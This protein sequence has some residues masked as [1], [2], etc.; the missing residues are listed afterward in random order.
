MFLLT[1]VFVV[2][3]AASL[4][5]GLAMRR[6]ATRL[7]VVVPPRP[8]RWHSASTPTMGGVGIAAATL[9]GFGG[10]ALVPGVLGPVEEWVPVL[11][12]AVAMFL[13]G[14]LDDRLQLSPVAKL[15]ASL[16]IGAFL[17]SALAASVPGPA[18]PTVYTLL[19]TIGFAGLCH[20]INLLDNMDGL[21]AGVVLI[22]AAFLAGLFGGDLGLPL[23]ALLV[24]VAGALLGFLCW[25]RPK[26]R[27]F[28][29]DSGSL[30]IGAVVGGASLVPLFGAAGPVALESTVLVVLV[31]V[32]PLFD[33]GFVLILRRLAGRSATRGGTDHVSHR[34]VSLGFSERRAV[35]ALY[36]LGAVGGVV[37]VAARAGGAGLMLAVA[38]L[39]LVVVMLLGIYLARVP[40]YYAEDFQALQ[41]SSFAPFLKDLAF[42][43]HAGEV[44]PDLVLIP[45][46]YYFAYRLRFEGAAFDENLQYFTASLPIVLGLK[47][48]SLYGSG[49]YQRSWSTFELRDVAVVLRGVWMGSLLAVLAVAFLYRFQG[50]SR[51]VFLIDGILLTVAVVA[52]RASFQAMS[53]V[54]SIRSKRSRRVVVYGAG[55]FGQLLVREMRAN[56]KWR[57]NPVAFI[58][59]D[60]LKRHRWIVGVPVRG[61]IDDLEDTVRKHGADE[62]IL[63]SPSVNG[64]MEQRIREICA[65]LDRP[66]R[67]FR[68]EIR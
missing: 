18:V 17:V 23:I 30:F 59:D 19:A 11:A 45:A 22:A 40:A 4:A 46:C 51:V 32:V 61:A 43:W 56:A 29:G 2:A 20:A 10:A 33:T 3:V 15:V 7:G 42:R 35:R 47:L 62:V 8:D 31:L 38:P 68:M 24:A 54:V 64:P 48:A 6:V 50:F 49:L 1:T 5:G 13:V 55:A 57:M 41:K 65:G 9:M 28:M 67:R 21:A 25:N 58:D 27:L 52:T 39:F 66:V 53:L 14:V 63:S 44:M 60:P 12:A 34:L 26:A 36:G 16:A 37:A